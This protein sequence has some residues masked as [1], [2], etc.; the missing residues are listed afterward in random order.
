MVEQGIANPQVIDSNP[1]GYS[2]KGGSLVLEYFKARMTLDMQFLVDYWKF[3]LPLTIV[4]YI[5][6][7]YG[8]II[9]NA[10]K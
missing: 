9:R 8:N 1:I 7:I 3:I 6:M 5:G 2:I 4:I 10:S